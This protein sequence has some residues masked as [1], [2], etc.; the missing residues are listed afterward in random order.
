MNLKDVKAS[1]LAKGKSELIKRLNGGHLST[2]QAILAKC[3]E[4]CNGY[5]DGKVDCGIEDCALYEYMPFGKIRYKSEVKSK[6]GKKNANIAK[7]FKQNT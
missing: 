2:K 1:P 6:L 3:F 4:C 7:F 5:I